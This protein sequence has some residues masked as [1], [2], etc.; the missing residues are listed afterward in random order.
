MCKIAFWDI[1]DVSENFLLTIIWYKP[2]FFSDI[3]ELLSTAVE[4]FE[5]FEQQLHVMNQ[6]LKVLDEAIKNS[7]ERLK[8]ED[9]DLDECLTVWCHFFIFFS[10]VM[11]W[12]VFLL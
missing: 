11:V 3:L 5:D 4:Y 7:S 12:H 10:V 2:L 6:P 1:Y 9:N 8:G